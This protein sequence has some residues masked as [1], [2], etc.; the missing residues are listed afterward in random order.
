MRPEHEQDREILRRIARRAMLERGLVPDFPPGVATELEALGAT[1]PRD[2]PSG[3]LLEA[4]PGDGAFARGDSLSDLRHLPWASIDNDHTRDLDQLTVAE[5]ASRGRVRVLVAIADVDVFVKKGTAID[6]HAAQNT[7]SVYTPA[8]IFP[9]LP[10]ELSTGLTSLNPD[11]E[12]PALVVAMLVDLDGSIDTSEVFRARVCSRAKLA[13]DSVSAWLEGNGPMPDGMAAVEDLAENLRLQDEVARRMRI[14]RHRRGALS[15]E[16]VEAQP[17][18]DGDLV[19]GLAVAEKNRAKNLIEDFMIAANGAAARFL[20]SS[21]FPSIRRVVRT[22]RR[23][24]R[25]VEIADEH[26]RRLPAA[27]DP[28][29]L[30]R[31]LTAMREEDRTGFADLS[32]AVT[33]LLG[34]GEYVANAPGEDPPAHFGLAVKDY[35][36]STAPNRRFTDLVTQR[37]LKAV[38]T[39]SI[40]PYRV[41]ELSDLALHCTKQEDAANKVERQVGKSAAALYLRRQ[42][43]Q[44]FEAMVTGA[45]EKGTWVRLVGLPVEGRVVEGFRDLDVGHRVSVQLVSVDVERG[46]IDFKQVGR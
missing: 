33:K 42:V 1:E 14:N 23:W 40:A 43:G 4:A 26:G 19:S 37:L 13:Y 29:A 17:V 27:P 46:F 9:M 28:G 36:H 3:P 8:Q 15:L 10:I 32:L 39:G 20:A 11:E 45:A 18:F 38:L 44:Q 25:I 34:P 31:F 22:P 41:E 7:T 24:E 12:R 6:R 5:T 21:G 30:E 2:L 35:G 16:T